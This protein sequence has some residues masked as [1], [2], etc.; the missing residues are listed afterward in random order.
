MLSEDIISLIIDGVDI[1]TNSEFV[2]KANSSGDKPPPKRAFIQEASIDSFTGVIK[3]CFPY[4]GEQTHYRNETFNRLKK[5]SRLI[6][7]H[8]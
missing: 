1:M 7:C 8:R 2:F 3:S 6:R 4:G 5:V